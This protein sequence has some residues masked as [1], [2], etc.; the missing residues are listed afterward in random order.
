MGE[1]PKAVMDFRSQLAGAGFKP[2]C[3]CFC[4]EQRCWASKEKGYHE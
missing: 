4:K 2:P 1:W 3:G